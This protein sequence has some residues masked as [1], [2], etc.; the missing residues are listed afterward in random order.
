MTKNHK[1]NP[2]KNS[3]EKSQREENRRRLTHRQVKWLPFLGGPIAT[4]IFSGVHYGYRAVRGEV[5][6]S[7]SWIVTVIIIFVLLLIYI[8]VSIEIYRRYIKYAKQD[9]ATESHL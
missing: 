1:P 8:W 2:N 7:E 5:S 3:K 4:L 6:S 9:H